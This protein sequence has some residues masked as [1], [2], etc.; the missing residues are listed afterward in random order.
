MSSSNVGLGML[1]KVRTAFTI[2]GGLY[3]VAIGLLAVPFFQTQLR[4]SIFAFA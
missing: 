4:F 2:A 1:S 3:A